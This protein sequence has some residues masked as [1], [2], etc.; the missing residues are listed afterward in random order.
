MH[1]NLSTSDSES[2]HFVAS[3]YGRTRNHVSAYDALIPST[4]DSGMVDLG[5]AFVMATPAKPSP[6]KKY[7]KNKSCANSAH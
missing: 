6:Y 2:L 1:T 3:N 4:R 5:F 7:S